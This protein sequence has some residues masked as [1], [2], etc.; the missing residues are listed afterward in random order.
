MDFRG[1][2]PRLFSGSKRIVGSVGM[3]VLSFFYLAARYRGRLIVERFILRLGRRLLLFLVACGRLLH[4]VLVWATGVC[5]SQ[6]QWEAIVPR[7]DNASL[8]KGECAS[9]VAYSLGAR[10]PRRVVTL[11]GQQRRLSVFSV[12]LHITFVSGMSGSVLLSVF[13]YALGTLGTSEEIWLVVVFRINQLDRLS[14]IIFAACAVVELWLRRSPAE[15]LLSLLQQSTTQ[16][17]LRV[18]SS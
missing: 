15:L 10:G 1:R 12:V 11:A 14:A 7:D 18:H 2:Y 16:F 9:V 5:T 17:L 6:R 4:L 13:P 3:Y 8:R